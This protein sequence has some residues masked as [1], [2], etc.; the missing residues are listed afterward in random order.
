MLKKY[1][2]INGGHSNYI[3]LS[4]V[5]FNDMKFTNFSCILKK[6]RATVIA[7]VFALEKPF[8]LI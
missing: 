8:D 3:I 5:I 6:D 7:I 1:H 2:V 4:L